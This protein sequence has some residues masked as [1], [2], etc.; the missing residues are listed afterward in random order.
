MKPRSHASRLFLRGLALVLPLILTLSLLIWVWQF[1]SEKVFTHVDSFV[2]WVIERFVLW[3]S[4]EEQTADISQLIEDLVPEPVRLGISVA[5]SVLLVLLV[6]WWFSGFLGR[7]AVQIFERW[8][9]RLPLVS[10]IYP[11]IKQ[12]VDFFLGGDERQLPFD[13]VVALPY[14]RQGLYSLGFLTGGSLRKLNRATET[15]LVSVFIPSSP[16]PMT[17]YTLFV[18]LS[19][20]VM[21]DMTVDEAL[22][23]VVS[24]GVLI[25][26][27]HAEDLAEKV[28][29]VAGNGKNELPEP[30]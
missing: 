18:P 26:A 2:R 30:E 11:H 12:V 14:P 29:A 22:R 3:S 23:T 24:G 20:L 25:P 6:G 19:D 17:G 5:V 16:M 9:V 28:A 10:A 21:I 13:R 15:D 8:L 27:E 4:E 1:L 7:R